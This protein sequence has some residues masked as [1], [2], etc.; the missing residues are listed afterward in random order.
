[1]IELSTFT[2][3]LRLNGCWKRLERYLKAKNVLLSLMDDELDQLAETLS[4]VKF[5]R[6]SLTEMLK[7]LM[8]AHPKLLRKLRRSL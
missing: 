7:A 2:A 4:G 6:I 3:D 5:D 1:L 8:K